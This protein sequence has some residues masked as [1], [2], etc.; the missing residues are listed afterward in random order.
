MEVCQNTAE[1]RSDTYYPATRLAVPECMGMSLD[2][3]GSP[4]T[5]K[6]YMT[7]DDAD[8]ALQNHLRRF[9]SKEV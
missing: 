7:Q 6:E 2:F 1:G 8:K 4:I 3:D 9:H 5:Y